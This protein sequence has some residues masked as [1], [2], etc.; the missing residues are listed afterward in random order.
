MV[1]VGLAY[2]L[3]WFVW[4]IRIQSFFVTH[5]DTYLNQCSFAASIMATKNPH[6]FAGWFFIVFTTGRFSNILISICQVVFTKF[7]LRPKLCGEEDW[8]CPSIV[9]HAGFCYRLYRFS[10]GLLSGWLE[11]KVRRCLAR[12]QQVHWQFKIHGLLDSAV[13]H[14]GLATSSN[15]A[16]TFAHVFLHQ[17]V[18]LFRFCCPVAGSIG[19]L[20]LAGFQDGVLRPDSMCRVWQGMNS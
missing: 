7:C 5:I 6:N 2:S 4:R 14:C 10:P 15:M 12:K 11:G 17:V 18:C 19:K 16:A 13:Q 20:H 1:A 3:V 8:L 9:F